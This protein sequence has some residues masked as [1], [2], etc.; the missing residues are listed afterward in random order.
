[1]LE[2]LEYA[3]RDQGMMFLGRTLRDF[4]PEDHLLLQVERL[5]D[6]KTLVRPFTEAYCPDNGRPGVHP[7]I[8]VRA[9]LLSRLYGIPSFRRLCEEIGLNLA[10]RYFCHLPLDEPV[11][12]HSTITR[13]LDRVGREAFETLC[14][15]LTAQ[16]A[17]QGWLSQDTYLDSTLVEANASAEGLLPSALGAKAFAEAVVEANGLFQGPTGPDQDAETGRYQDREGRLPLPPSDLDA[18]WA[19]GAKG[20]AK[21][22]YRVSALADD[23]GFL[24]GQRVDLATAA[25][26]E[27]GEWLLAG[28]PP[29]KTVA[30]DKA[31]SAG[32]FR[33]ALRERG[34][35]TYIPLP[36]GHPPAFLQTQGFRF[37]PF[38]MTCSEGRQLRARHRSDKP[39]IRYRAPRA[40]CGSCQRSARCPA[41]RRT[42]FDLGADTKE[43]VQAQAVNKTAAYRRGQ[44][45]RRAVVEGVFAQLKWYGLRRV[46]LRGLSRVAIEL[47]LAA[48]A[49]NVLKLVRLSGRSMPKAPAAARVLCLIREGCHA[50]T[51]RYR[52]RRFFNRPIRPPLRDWG[53]LRADS[54]GH[55]AAAW[56]AAGGLGVFPTF[57]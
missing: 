34:I 3:R 13:F 53:P 57:G 4:L 44:R 18:R 30:A 17:E 52:R 1:M 45:R 12:D 25:D 33:A 55:G 22:S 2:P 39:T 36:S 23:H 47:E 51:C 8:L 14:R 6:F 26:H 31:Y 10:Y 16:L 32:A 9:L 28:V 7:E 27:A 35:T 38:T 46:K 20:P 21:L 24:V 48:F 5:L 49:H 29:P 56:G 40:E 41:A 37:G 43:L 54:S 15:S 50:I 42:G 11:F 19:K